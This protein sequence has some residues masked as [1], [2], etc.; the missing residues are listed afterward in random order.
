MP[1]IRF[2]TTGKFERSP[3]RDRL[4]QN[5][6]DSSEQD[7]CK[8][9]DDSNVTYLLGESGVHVDCPMD[10]HCNAMRDYMEE[11]EGIYVE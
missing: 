2:S 5:V 10:S 9:I 1:L 11:F 7:R 3:C 8:G 4:N 6:L